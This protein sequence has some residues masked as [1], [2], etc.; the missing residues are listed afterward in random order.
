MH[1]EPLRH[2]VGYKVSKTQ[3]SDSSESPSATDTDAQEPGRGLPP[4]M[5]STQGRS[6]L[7]RFLR[8]QQCS[9]WHSHRKVWRQ[10][11][12]PSGGIPFSRREVPQGTARAIRQASQGA[13]RKREARNHGAGH[14]SKLRA[15][16]VYG[17][18]HCKDYPRPD[19]PGAGR[20]YK[21]LFVT[22]MLRGLRLRLRS[23]LL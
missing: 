6:P 16:V 12:V 18:D 20:L 15:F 1:C 14:E 23:P 13:A 4:R 2:T 22:L 9:R 3:K 5:P 10:M 19:F 8:K 17:G 21:N 11:T 7:A